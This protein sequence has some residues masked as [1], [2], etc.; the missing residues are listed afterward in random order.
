MTLPDWNENVLGG[1][2]DVNV[3]N[4]A[5]KELTLMSGGVTE[6][7]VFDDTV[8]DS[9]SLVSYL[10]NKF[11]NLDFE[12]Q[13]G[14]LVISTGTGDEIRASGSAL[15]DLLGTAN[16]SEKPE[17]N[18]LMGNINVAS[19]RD[20]KMGKGINITLTDSDSGTQS[21]DFEFDGCNSISDL[22]DNNAGGRRR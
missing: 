7:C 1:N 18:A 9:S 4:L 22:I 2:V 14:K 17:Y 19:W 15:T 6:T 21:F 20:D 16:S 5:G 13:G 11:N 3:S 8:T 10:E 12:I